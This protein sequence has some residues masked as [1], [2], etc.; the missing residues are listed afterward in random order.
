[1]YVEAST[2]QN[3][4]T[5]YLW[6]SFR[7]SFT[8][9]LRI[10]NDDSEKKRQ[11]RRTFFA[12]N[13]IAMLNACMPYIKFLRLHISGAWELGRGV[14]HSGLGIQRIVCK[15]IFE[16]HLFHLH[17][18]SLYILV[19]AFPRSS[20]SSMNPESYHGNHEICDSTWFDH[21]SLRKKDTLCEWSV[22]PHQQWVIC[23]SAARR[24]AAS[25]CCFL[26]IWLSLLLVKQ[27]V[28]EWNVRWQDNKCLTPLLVLVILLR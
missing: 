26:Y 19:C 7:Y 15:A 1:M 23:L 4:Q 6:I 28:F 18:A 24:W 16:K 5:L 3:I 14:C 8:L 10:A 21:F 27:D 2:V 9:F 22:F 13:F 17:C 20:F 25:L 12:S 11:K